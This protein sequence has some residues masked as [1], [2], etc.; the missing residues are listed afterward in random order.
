MIDTIG[1][2]R[3]PAILVVICMYVVSMLCF[4]GLICKNYHDNW[5]QTLGLSGIIVWSLGRASSLADRENLSLDQ[6]LA[7]ASWQ[8]L[9][10]ADTVSVYQLIGA[11]SMVLFGIGTAWKVWKYRHRNVNPNGVANG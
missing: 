6:I 3:V 5:F 4:F 2:V 10:R 8:T 1:D 7:I 11:L 9:D